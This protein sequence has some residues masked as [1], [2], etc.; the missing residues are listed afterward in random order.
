MN[1]FRKLLCTSTALS[2]LMASAVTQGQTSADLVQGSLD[3]GDR[4]SAD[5]VDD[6]RRMPLEVLAFAGIEEGMTILEMEAGGGYYRESMSRA[7]GV[8]CCQLLQI[9]PAFVGF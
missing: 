7:V 4:P 8:M 1:I 6:A 5:A 2:I 9:L 3:S